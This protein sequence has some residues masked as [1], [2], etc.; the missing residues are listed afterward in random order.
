MN[1]IA[2]GCDRRYRNVLPRPVSID[3]RG[4]DGRK[5]REP[6][7]GRARLLTHQVVQRAPDQQEKQKGRRRVKI[8]VRRAMKGIVEAKAEG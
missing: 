8:S 2:P 1:R 3:D 7:D 6:R 4:A 5:P